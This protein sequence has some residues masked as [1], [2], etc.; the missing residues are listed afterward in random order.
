M[1]ACNRT[2]WTVVVENHVRWQLSVA[3][4]ADHPTLIGLLPG[5]LPSTALVGC[6]PIFRWRGRGSEGTSLVR[7]VGSDDAK[8]DQIDSLMKAVLRLKGCSSNRIFPSRRGGN[9]GANP[10]EAF[11]PHPLG[12]LRQTEPS[13]NLFF[14]CPLSNPFSDF[15]LCVFVVVLS[16]I[17]ISNRVCNIRR[18]PC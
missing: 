7:V 3:G 11:I 8:N 14:I 17:L 13:G 4:E 18:R 6:T 10:P 5:L 2:W 9:G 1:H 16:S 12:E 15:G